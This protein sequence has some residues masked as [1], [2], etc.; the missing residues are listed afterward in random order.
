MENKIKITSPR[1][2]QIA[3]DV[4]AKIVDGHYKVGD[5]IYARSS[6]ASQ[7][8]VS[9]E[10]ARRAICVLSDLNIVDTSKGSGVT[11]K[12]YENAIKF[13]KQ[14]NDISTISNL[15]QDIID[16]VDRQK[17]EIKFLYGCLSDLIDKTD[18]FR[19]VNPFT[20]FQIEITSATPY[21]NKSVSDINFWHNTSATIIAIRRNDSLLMS[22]G[23]YAIFQENDIFY[24]VGDENCMERVK[25]FI[26]P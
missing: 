19:S 10:T 3:A 24:F 4:A 21:I 20:P 7:Y 15:K 1:Y 22:P 26:Y 12:S 2:Q 25:K 11:I 16:S 17:K 9:S 14:Y 6:L 8:G 23:P 18:R 5:K 13:I